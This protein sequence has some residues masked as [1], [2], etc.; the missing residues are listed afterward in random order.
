MKIELE[1]NYKNCVSNELLVCVCVVW[2]WVPTEARRRIRFPGFGAPALCQR[3]TPGHGTD[4][5]CAWYTQ[6]HS[7]EL[8]STCLCGLSARIEGANTP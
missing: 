4:L 6:E 5:E 8:R 7:T 2:I 3:A 1:N